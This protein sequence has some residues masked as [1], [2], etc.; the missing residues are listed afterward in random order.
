MKQ[1]SQSIVT[2]SPEF[3][4]GALDCLDAIKQLQRTQFGHVDFEEQYFANRESAAAAIIEAAGPV[5]DRAA[6]VLALLAEF[7]VDLEDAGENNADTWQPKIL[8]TPDQRE[9]ARQEFIREINEPARNN[10][11]QLR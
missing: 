10:V 4:A 6:G 3:L 7:M 5:T 9:T 2:T 8:M 11:M 1:I